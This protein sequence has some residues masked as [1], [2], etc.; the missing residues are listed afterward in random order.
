[1]A[2][3]PTTNGELSGFAAALASNPQADT[4]R[5]GMEFS[6]RGETTNPLS[7]T[8]GGTLV[9]D[10]AA[11]DANG[12]QASPFLG[13]GPVL[14][15]PDDKVF[16]Q[17]DGMVL[18]QELL[19][20]NRLAQDSFYTCL[21]SG[22]PWATL[23]HDTNRD[24]YT[25]S[26]PYGASQMTIQAVPNKNLDLVNKTS[27]SLLVDFPEGTA[28]PIDD[29]EEAQ[30]A[31]DLAN[32][33][34]TLSA[35]EQGTN[36]AVL[37][38]DRVKRALVTASTFVEGWVDPTG[39]GYVPLQ[40]NAHPQAVSPLEPLLGPDGNVTTDPI[41]RYV[42]GPINPD[43]TPGEGSQFTTD[44]SEAAPQWQ[45]AIK[46]S[47]WQREHLRVFPEDKSVADA[48]QVI[49]LGYCTL[50]E[51]KLRWPTV[52]QMSQDELSKL[53]DW[54]PQ[55]YLV[56][57]PPFQR[58]RWQ[59]SDGRKEKDGASDERIMF[60]Y[61]RYVRSS[62]DHPRGADVVMT[63]AMGGMVL[64]RRLLASDVPVKKGQ[65]ETKEIR[66]REIPVVQVTPRGDPN[67][68][69][70]MGLAYLELFVGATEN[71]ASLAM[72]FAEALQKTLHTPFAIP[73]T[74][75]IEGWQVD[76]ARASGD[77]LVI[78]R[79]E[80]KPTQLNPPVLPT[81][82]FEMYNLADQAVNSIAVQE[83]AAQGAE[84]ADEKSGKALQIAIGRNQVAASPM[85]NAVNNAVARWDR[86][87]LELAM[88]EY[89]NPQLI[90]YEGE[91]GSYKT[92]EFR[93]V[94][95]ALVGQVTIKPG[96]GTGFDPV[97][98]VNYLSQLGA[99]RLLSA[100]EVAEAAR[101]AFAKRL[102]LPPNPHEQY[103][104]RCIASWLKGPPEPPANAP[105]NPM[106][107]QPATWA[108]QYRAWQQGEAQAQ[109]AMQVYQQQTARF[110]QYQQF[111]AVAQ[112]GAPPNT[113]GPQQQY[114]QAAVQHAQAVQWLQQNADASAPPQQ[115]QPNMV[116]KPWT[117]FRAR[118]NDTEPTVAAIWMRKLSRA[119]SGVKYDAF[120]PEWQDVL[121]QQYALVRNAV[122]QVSTP[123]PQAAPP[124]P[125]GP[126]QRAAPSG[127][128]SHAQ[129]PQQPTQPSPSTPHAPAA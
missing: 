121:D 4:P 22:Y 91:D 97:T 35:G 32:R 57:L 127:P 124:A 89:T 95:F 1:M 11:F 72:G 52:A 58:A 43:G 59:L 27:A 108:D 94:D 56:L 54:Q 87:K 44:A 38:D 86:V 8:Q 39:G 19:A 49:I 103:V 125:T 92:T 123:Q 71:T 82:F 34:L 28:E 3:K 6:F 62:P 64:D 36:D 69:D 76:E 105:V 30:A 90:K 122:A 83:R 21:V 40:I 109:Q 98:K 111:L 46:A 29:S 13:M 80:D 15:D 119:M 17:T 113:L 47:L 41:L 112:A 74:S 99:N 12:V 2:T 107:G 25:F 50:G 117:P 24:L 79:P 26:L 116:P 20:R 104:E 31:A 7:P 88:A 96:T 16:K 61:H 118:P 10:G 42:T 93:G 63:G 37:F 115:P 101:P 51:A 128:Q 9:G 5:G 129:A 14:E 106:A 18:R 75:P 23:T 60:Y 48:Q 126:A 110:Q 81:S 85:Q 102:G 67:G 114:D 68:R 66:C 120:G 78:Q 84:N 77:F 65:G 53:C 45:P 33:F 100:D 70:P 55:R 73:S